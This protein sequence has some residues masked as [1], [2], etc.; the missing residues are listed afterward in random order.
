MLKTSDKQCLYIITDY[1]E[2]HE[3]LSVPNSSLKDYLP[4]RDRQHG[5]LVRNYPNV[6][7]DDMGFVSEEL[8][9]FCRG[10]EDVVD[11]RMRQQFVYIKDERLKS[12][13]NE[14][15]FFQNIYTMQAIFLTVDNVAYERETINV[16]HSTSPKQVSVRRK[17]HENGGEKR[18]IG[19]DC[20]T[21]ECRR[22]RWDCVNPTRNT[23]SV[24]FKL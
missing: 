21:K 2:C 17:P 11:D 1:F 13:H 7:L 14:L 5:Y 9:G 16:E 23:R 10:T 3:T 6:T 8:H 18:T 15:K 22:Q 4:W 19:D 12:S 20:S 24:S